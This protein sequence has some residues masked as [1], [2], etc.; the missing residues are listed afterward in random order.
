MTLPGWTKEPLVHFL[1]AGGLLFALFAWIGEPVDPASRSIVVGKEEQAR[2]ALQWE[3]TNGRPPTDA[4]LAAQIDRFVRDEVLYREALRMGLDR[5]DAVVRQRMASKMD[6]L[7]ASAAE[8][9]KPDD[10]VLQDWLERH[11]TRFTDDARFGFEQL[12][13]AERGTAE[14]ALA[15]G[16]QI[17]GEAISL[18]VEERNAPRSEVSARFGEEFVAALDRLEPGPK[19]QGPVQSGFGWHLVRLTEKRAGEVPPL[20]EVRQQVENDWRSATAEAR[21]EEGY[22]ILRDGYDVQIEK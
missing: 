14:A 6:Y 3:L 18:P 22:R 5:D 9:A 8:T 20:A 15:A 1:A 16:G 17:R 21:R 7:A 11:P 10:S 19:W 4:E 2:I 12:Y 13:F